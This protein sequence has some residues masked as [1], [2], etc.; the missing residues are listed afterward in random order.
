MRGLKLSP[1]LE[2]ELAFVIKELGSLPSICDRCHT[3]LKSYADKCTADICDCCPGF[4]AIENAKEKFHRQR[5]RLI[6][7]QP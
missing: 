4:L 6:R 5:P 7:G 3:Q 2:A 1:V